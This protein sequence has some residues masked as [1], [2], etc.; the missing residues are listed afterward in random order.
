MQ[1]LATLIFDGV[2]DRFP[3][4]RIGVIEQGCSWVP[5]WMKQMESAMDAFGRHEERL[6]K[7]SLRPTSSSNGRCASRRTRPRTSDG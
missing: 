4:L 2:L 5:S 1:T 6:Q 7:L 3:N